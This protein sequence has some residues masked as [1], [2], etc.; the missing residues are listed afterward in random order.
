MF[1]CFKIIYRVSIKSCR[2]YFVKNDIF[3]LINAILSYLY[4]IYC[5]IIQNI[6]RLTFSAFL[7]NYY[8]IRGN[9]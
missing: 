9:E 4:A 8:V 2:N 3:F 6:Y 7:I 1:I 5:K